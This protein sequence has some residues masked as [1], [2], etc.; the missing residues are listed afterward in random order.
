MPHNIDKSRSRKGEYIGYA[1]G[2]WR[3]KRVSHGR[4]EAKAF[5]AILRDDEPVIHFA[6]SLGGIS[7]ALDGVATR[8][9]EHAKHAYR[10]RS[11]PNPFETA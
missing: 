8:N 2:T 7:K 10:S 6:S 5:N 1:C 9:E 4:W 3:I 11:L